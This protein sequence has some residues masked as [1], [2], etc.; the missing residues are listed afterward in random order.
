MP[1]KKTTKKG[2][3]IAPGL[4]NFYDK[5]PPEMIPKFDNP[6]KHLHEMTIPFRACVVGPSGSGKTSWLCNL[7]HLFS[8]GTKGT[9]ASISIVTAN[10]DEPL[11]NYLRK[12]DDGIK[13]YE[14]I[15]NTPKLDKF[16]K[17]S[18][19][20][21]LSHVVIWDDLVL[22]KHLD[23]VC[24][25]YIRA[26]K[27]H[28]SCVFISQSYYGIPLMIR[29]NTNYLVLLKLQGSRD[30]NSIMRE[31]ALGLTKEQLIGLYEY[32]TQ[33]HMSPLII[34]FNETPDK[35]FRKGFT[36]LLDAR[37]FGSMH[38]QYPSPLR[39]DDSSSSDS[40]SD[41]EHRGYG[42]RR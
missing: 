6:N 38:H 29:R 27:Q 9:F 42:A 30:I 10:S 31:C 22:S 36:Q 23:I 40:E 3:E 13:V 15:G 1:P 18:K 14:G 20:Q 5:L 7:L 16:D 28:V 26:R 33:Q 25:Y 2:A 17:G 19:D 4:I 37:Q 21:P 8:Q 34:D 32:A 12:L 39:M 24:N 35:R 11:Y 41:E